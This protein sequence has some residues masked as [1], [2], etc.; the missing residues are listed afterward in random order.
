MTIK[1]YYRIN[2]KEA[3]LIS[4]AIESMPSYIEENEKDDKKKGKML[5]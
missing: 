1:K 3:D 2:Q 5:S 4:K